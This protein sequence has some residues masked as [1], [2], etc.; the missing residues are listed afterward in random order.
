[1]VDPVGVGSWCR[2]GRHK[3][4]WILDE[5]LR[6]ASIDGLSW[7]GEWEGW[8]KAYA[9]GSGGERHQR[10]SDTKVSVGWLC[11]TGANAKASVSPEEGWANTKVSVGSL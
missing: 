8:A 9:I 3:G 5:P 1:M 7:I 4:P 11:R 6:S 10:G 2:R